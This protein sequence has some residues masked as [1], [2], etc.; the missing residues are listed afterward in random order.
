MLAAPAPFPH[1]GS[2]AFVG[3][4]AEPVTII[5][6]NA[7]GT[8]LVRVDPRPTEGRN[9]DASGNTTVPVDQLYPSECEAA[10]ADL[11]IPLKG[12]RKDQLKALRN[13]GAISRE[14]A[15]AV[16]FDKTFSPGT[17]STMVGEGLVENAYMPVG[18]DAKRRCSHY[19]LTRT[20]AERAAALK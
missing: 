20:G 10:A 3:A 11:K 2:R 17:L 15:V 4:T 18:G 9:R 7:D 5:R 6:K 13:A 16:A 19:W 8:A 14:T 12:K 1:A